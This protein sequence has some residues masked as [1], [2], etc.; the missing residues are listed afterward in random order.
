MGAAPMGAQH[1]VLL[2]G[3]AHQP[4]VSLVGQADTAYAL[5]GYAQAGVSLAQGGVAMKIWVGT[6]LRLAVRF[7]DP[8]GL[9]ADPTQVVCKVRDPVGAEQAVTY[10]VDEGIVKDADGNFHMDVV[11]TMGGTYK[12]RWQGTG[13]V[14]AAV[15]GF[16]AVEPSAFT[17]PPVV[18]V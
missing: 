12:Y 5:L 10:G 8:D 18:P 15:E 13:A 16:V 11:P 17:P 4:V 14:D 6:K 3:A 1:S 2:F 9:D 7:T